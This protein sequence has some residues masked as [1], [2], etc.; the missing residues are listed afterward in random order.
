MGWGRGWGGW[1]PTFDA[2]SRNAKI[3]NFHLQG[4]E[5]GG[6]RDMEC[7]EFG[8]PTYSAFGVN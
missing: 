7:M 6:G 3:P 4:G 2:E 1:Q 8:A 5:V